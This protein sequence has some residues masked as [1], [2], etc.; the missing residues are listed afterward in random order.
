MQLPRDHHYNPR[1]VL[2]RWTQS[3]GPLT[4]MRLVTAASG[5]RKVVVSRKHPS[6]TGKLRDLY[7]TAN[8]PEAN[9][10]LVEQ[11]FMSPLDND[12]AVALDKLIAGAVLSTRD[13][14]AWARFLLSLLYRHPEGVAFIKN[15]TTAMWAEATDALEAEWAL[16]RTTT[17]A[18]TFAEAT[19]KRSPGAPDMSAAD[20]LMDVIEGSRAVPDIAAMVW[21]CAELTRSKRSLLTSD[22]GLVMPF[23]L[24][25]PDC[26]IALPLGPRHLFIAARDDRFVR[27]LPSADHNKIAAQMNKDV[28]EQARQYV[29]D[30]DASQLGFVTKHFAKLPDRAI[31][32]DEQ[33]QNILA[34]ARGKGKPIIAS[35]P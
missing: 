35:V 7:R 28:V 18:L 11:D 27:M 33:R 13:R 5:Q 8:V 32:T 17:D 9:S 30:E 23:G 29:W 31:L 14:E 34:V 20:M 19:A 10:Q 12:A 1:F 6:G 21:T 3:N 24:S 22:R 15:H 4:E 16:R 2:K 25:H 26:H